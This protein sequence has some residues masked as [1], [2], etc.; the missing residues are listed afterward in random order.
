MLGA[1]SPSR[2]V[3]HSRGGMAQFVGVFENN[4]ICLFCDQTTEG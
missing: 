3:Q 1:L 2:S 4:T